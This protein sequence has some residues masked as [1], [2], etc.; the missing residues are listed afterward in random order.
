M[1][2]SQAR[3]KNPAEAQGFRLL[4]VA[5][6]LLMVV[7]TTGCYSHISMTKLPPNSDK[8][9]ASTATT[10]LF[11]AYLTS[12]QVT[13]NGCPVNMNPTFEQRFLGRLQET[14][15][16]SDVVSSIGR[17]KRAEEPHFELVL[18]V[19]ETQYLHSFSNGI[20]GFFIGVSLFLLTPV[21]PNHYEHEA[22]MTLT[23]RAP[24]SVEKEYKARARGSAYAT[25]DRIQMANT[26][27]VGGVVER[28]I[29]SIMN[30][31]LDDGW[32]RTQR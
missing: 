8:V 25:L 26:K 6:S 31:L 30:Q 16:F 5:L 1:N 19:S 7:L 15:L 23:V 2:F 24:N 29:N 22:E 21:L 13:L 12:I 10:R 18:H 27:V 28:C 17:E 14:R 20:K 3:R 32:L 4:V 9:V 11:A